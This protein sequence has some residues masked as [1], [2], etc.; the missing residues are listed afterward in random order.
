MRGKL[1]EMLEQNPLDPKGN[2]KIDDT[3]PRELPPLLSIPLGPSLGRTVQIN[4]VTGTDLGRA[5]R[6]LDIACARNRVKTDFHRQRFHER[7]GLKRK[8]LR[9][10]RWRAKFK[11]GF[12]GMVK[13]IGDMRRQ[14]W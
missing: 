6:A 3:K 1:H 8:R 2:T 4:N 9:S 10:V 7:P 12:R 11:D 5:F 14:G 13:M